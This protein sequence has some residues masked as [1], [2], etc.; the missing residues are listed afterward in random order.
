MDQRANRVVAQL[1]EPNSQ[2][3]FLRW[4]F[5]NAIFEQKEYAE[6][7]IMEGLA[8]KM[9]A[10]SPALRSEFESRLRSDSTFAKSPS[11]RLQFFYQHSSYWDDR[12]GEYP[13]RKLL[14]SVN[15]KAE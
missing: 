6:D 11:E 15:L 14:K 3:S 4:G 1:L 9:I 7:Y 10:E 12:L 13:I 8:P 5:F 2:D